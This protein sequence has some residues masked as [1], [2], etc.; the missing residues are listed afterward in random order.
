MHFSHK[1]GLGTVQFGLSY[2]ISNSTGQTTEGEVGKILN[3]AKAFKIDILDSASAYGNSENVLGRNDLSAFKMVSKFMP[4]QDELISVQLENSLS[5]LG[6]SS[7][8]GYM[9]HRPSEILKNPSQWQELQYLKECRKVMKIGFSLNEP[10]ELFQLLEHKFYPD[11]VQ[12]PFNYFDRRFQTAMIKLKSEGC[13]IHTRS[14]F[15]QGLL[16]VDP[17]ELSSYF[18]EIKDHLRKLQRLEPLG[19]ALLKFVLQ[20]PFIDK[21]IIG[22]E[23]AIQLKQNIDSLAMAPSLPEFKQTISNK[24]LIPSR[25]PKC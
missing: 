12:V 4:P 11:I 25:W 21:V 20:K 14:A 24:I 2:G 5:A 10:E 1:L 13:E 23:N 9:A 8:Y 18:D 16:F 15:L 19:G 7:L 17:N 22:S 6:L 3:I